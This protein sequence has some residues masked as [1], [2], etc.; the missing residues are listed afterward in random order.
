MDLSN[1]DKTNSAGAKTEKFYFVIAGYAASKIVGDLL[2]K[3]HN[4]RSCN[5]KED[6]TNEIT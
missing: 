1:K 5:K 2:M 6:A 3:Y 4:E